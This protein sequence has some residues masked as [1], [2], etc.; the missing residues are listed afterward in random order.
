MQPETYQELCETLT[1]VLDAVERATGDENFLSDWR[2]W[3]RSVVDGLYYWKTAL[4]AV[5]A[6]LAAANHAENA[7]AARVARAAALAAAA[8]V[9][10]ARHEEFT[11]LTNAAAARCILETLHHGPSRGVP[12]SPASF[13][14]RPAQARN[15]NI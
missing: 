14:A 7:S 4:R 9:A 12:A 1:L 15:K 13:C 2:K 5:D 10:A 8:V 11:A 6:A 3:A